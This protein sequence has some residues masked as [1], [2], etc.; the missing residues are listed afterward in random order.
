ME[1]P[2][3]Q[4]VAEYFQDKPVQRAYLFGSHTR[5]EAG[6]SSDVDILVD[7]EPGYPMSLIEF[8]H[9]LE[10]LKELLHEEVDLVASDGLSPHLRPFIEREK[11]LVYEKA[12]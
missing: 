5:Q 3:P 2:L 6:L 10:D 1:K 9:M 12:A 11:V 7:V 4:L 8:G